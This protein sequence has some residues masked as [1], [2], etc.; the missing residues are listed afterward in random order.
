MSFM[1]N[2]PDLVEPKLTEEA[3]SSEDPNAGLRIPTNLGEGL[4]IEQVFIY[5]RNPNGRSRAG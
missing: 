1:A 2:E 3:S 5:L 4:P